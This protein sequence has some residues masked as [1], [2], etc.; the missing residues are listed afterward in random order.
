MHIATA[1]SGP[2]VVLLHGIPGS[3]ATWNAVAHDLLRD[4]R[5]HVADLLDH[6]VL[7]PPALAR[8][9]AETVDA[10]S[11]V[12]AGHDYGGP[13]ALTLAAAEPERV[14]GVLLAATNA[15]GDTP[16]PFPLSTLFL[17][18]LGG[19]AE[20]VLFSRPSLRMM[21]RQGTG[22]GGGK[23]D[24]AAALQRHAAVRAVFA[25][26]LRNLR[27]RFEPVEEA[28]RALDVPVAVLWG[29][30]D[31]FFAV[32]Q[33]HRTAQAASTTARVIEGAGHFLP[34][35]RPRELAAAIRELTRAG[36]RTRPSRARTRVPSAAR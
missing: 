9:L 36:A 10:P 7:T 31:P 34:E 5:V 27:E 21:I 30:R 26:T 25:D 28:L 17:P 4:H 18:V 29:D 6:D 22:T 20:R 14:T 11:F 13:V 24:A 23:P 19:V 35:E 15:F 33:A 3:P 8:A 16:V 2:D 32:K 12:V 1:G